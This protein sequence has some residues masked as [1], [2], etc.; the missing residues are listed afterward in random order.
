MVRYF[1]R[2]PDALSV[3]V[4]YLAAAS[5]PSSLMKAANVRREGVLEGLSILCTY[6]RETWSAFAA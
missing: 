6:C 2:E 1:N 5:W 3:S 4:P